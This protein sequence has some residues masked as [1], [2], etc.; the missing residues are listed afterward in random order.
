MTARRRLRTVGAALLAVALA[1]LPAIASDDA[2]GAHVS[3]A[4]A[5]FAKANETTGTEP[6]RDAFRE[7]AGLYEQ[8]LAMGHRNGALEYN[9]GNACFLA[10]D[11]GRAI[12]HYRRALVLRPGDPR[13]M[14]NLS[15]ARARRADQID[16]TAGRAVLETV[17]FWHRGLSLRSKVPGSLAAWAAAF[18]LLSVAVWFAPGDRRRLQM[19]RLAAVLLVVA[20]AV[21]VSAVVEELERGE[22]DSA[23]VV[24]DEVALRKGNG[25]SYPARYANPIHA[26][27]EIRVLEARGGWLEVELPDGKS[28][29]LPGAMI[30]RI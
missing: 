14:A 26:G 30:E 8:A 3:Q 21:G 28:G 7:A 27:T 10:G 13:V 16:D 12:L 25:A 17:V 1:V 15:T 5:A 22:R 11:V 6:R 23:V 19:I 9:A 2:I 20:A 18:A 29:W 24:A 4:T